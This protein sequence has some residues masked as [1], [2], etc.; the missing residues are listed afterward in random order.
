[1]DVQFAI[2]NVPSKTTEKTP[3]ELYGYHPRSGLDAALIDEVSTSAVLLEDIVKAR[4]EA[5]R[6][7]A[8]AQVKSKVAYDKKRKSHSN[9]K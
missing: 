2:N 9:I 6:Q 1:M 7:I 4:E 8:K 3:S 5:Y